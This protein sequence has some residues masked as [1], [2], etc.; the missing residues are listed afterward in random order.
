MAH[1]RTA[2]EI[3]RL[4]GRSKRHIQRLGMEGEIP[5]CEVAP[6]GYHRRYLASR[7]LDQWITREKGTKPGARRRLKPQK[8]DPSGTLPQEL[9]GHAQSIQLII[10][11]FGVNPKKRASGFRLKP[12]DWPEHRKSA[13]LNSMREIVEVYRELEA[14]TSSKPK[15][16]TPFK[17]WPDLEE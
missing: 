16:R 12:R 17:L 6:D 14:D 10:W 5:G 4:T 9:M 13:F 7:D 2:E 1:Y 3:A 11:E 15:P 8:Q